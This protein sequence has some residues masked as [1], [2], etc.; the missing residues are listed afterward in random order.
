MEGSL[1]VA[2]AQ[3]DGYTML[4]GNS[5]THAFSQVLYK[6]PPYNSVT[7]SPRSG[8]RRNRRAS[9]LPARICRQAIFKSSSPM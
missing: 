9:S 5:G 8:W 2:K 4:I 3:P 6:T 1:R 7:D